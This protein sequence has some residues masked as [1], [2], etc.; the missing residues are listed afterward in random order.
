MTSVLKL[1]AIYAAVFL[2]VII[3]GAWLSDRWPD[4]FFIAAVIIFGIP[5]VIGIASALLH[6]SRRHAR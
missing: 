4:T 3:P 5:W 6:Y 2:V 1:L